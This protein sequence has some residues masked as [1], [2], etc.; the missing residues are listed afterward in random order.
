MKN[1]TLDD[2]RVQSPNIADAGRR[3]LLARLAKVA[4][5]PTVIAAIAGTPKPAAAS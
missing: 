2:E 5:V 4:A 1:N 3:A